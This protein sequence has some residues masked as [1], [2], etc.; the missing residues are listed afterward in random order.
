MKVAMMSR[1]G[2]TQLAQEEMSEFERRE[3]EFRR[4]DREER[5]AQLRVSLN[6]DDPL[7]PRQSLRPSILS[8][9]TETTLASN[10]GLVVFVDPNRLLHQLSP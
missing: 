1:E 7:T 9:A 3:I 8:L 4:K 10:S 5:A 6:V 2:F